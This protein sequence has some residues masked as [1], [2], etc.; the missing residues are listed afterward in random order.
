MLICLACATPFPFENL[1]EGMTVEAVRENFGEPE[2]ME[3]NSGVTESCWSYVHEKQHWPITLILPWML[4]LTSPLAALTGC[5]WNHFYVMRSMVLLDFEE[6]KLIRWEVV[7][8]IMV[9]W[10]THPS[11]YP[12][13][14]GARPGDPD[15]IVFQHPAGGVMCFTDPPTCKSVR[16]Q[17]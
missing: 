4:P 12:T 14:R 1:E 15:Y 2:A 7:K 13:N 9:E 16:E 3:G 17:R 6:E 10:G 11:V 5:P 8:P